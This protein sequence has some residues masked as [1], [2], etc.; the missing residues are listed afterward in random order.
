M[1]QKKEHEK[2]ASEARNLILKTMKIC[3]PQR[4]MTLTYIRSERCTK[5][6]RQMTAATCSKREHYSVDEIIL[7]RLNNLFLLLTDEQ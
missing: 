5:E 1:D 3:Q 7:S 2:I 4:M 6:A